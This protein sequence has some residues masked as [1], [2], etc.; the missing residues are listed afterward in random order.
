MPLQ[1]CLGIVTQI[2]FKARGFTDEDL[3]S[4]K[5]IVDFFMAR[6]LMKSEPDLGTVILADWYQKNVARAGR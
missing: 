4:S 6:K 2:D 5:D 3:K 1:Q